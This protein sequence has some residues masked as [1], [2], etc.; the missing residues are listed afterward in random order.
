MGTYFHDDVELRYA[1]ADDNDEKQIEQIDA[2]ISEGINLL[3][4]SPNQVATISP[5]IDRAFDR[6]IPVIVFDRK[7]SS[8]KFTAYIGADNENMG[9]EMG[10]YIAAQLKGKGRVLEIMGLK[11]SSPAIERHQGFVMA[12]QKYPGI[13][14]VAS[15]Q[16][17]WTEKSGQQAIEGLRKTDPQKVSNIDYVFGQNDRMAVGAY[18][19]LDGAHNPQ[20][21]FCGIDALPTKGGGMECVRDGILTA[22]YIYPTH[23]DD[24]LQLAVNILKKKDY[25]KDNPLKGALVTKDNAHVLLMQ[26]EEMERQKEDLDQLH[27]K[28]DDTLAVLNNQNVSLITLIII[29]F[30]LIALCTYAYWAYLTK[31]RF[32]QQ[33]QESYERQRQ[34]TA[35]IEEMTKAQLMFFTN[36][37]HEF[38]TPLTLI[39]DPVDHLLADNTLTDSNRRL[40]TM[41]RRNVQ[42]LMQLINEVLDFR[43]V[44]SGKMELQ[45][46]TFDLREAIARWTADFETTA[47]KKGVILTSS[48]PEEAVPVEADFTKVARIYFN[49]MSNALKF[50][51]EGGTV[52]TRLRH[53]GHDCTLTVEDTGIGMDE[54][55][56][57]HIFD[58]F[59]QSKGTSGGTGI[60][61]SL[62]KAF[63]ELHHGTATVESRKGEGSAFTVVLPCR[64]A[65]VA[66][67][68]GGDHAASDAK[69]PQQ[70]SPEG[71]AAITNGEASPQEGSE[72]TGESDG[73]DRPTIL[74]IDDNADVRD[75]LNTILSPLYNVTMAANGEAGLQEA[76]REVPDLVVCDVMMPVMNGLEFCNRMKSETATSHIPVILLTARTLE[77]QQTEGYEHG[78]D[79][80][81]TKPFSSRL[82]L[83]RIDNL[84]RSRIQLKALFTTDSREQSDK[85]PQP[86]SADKQQQQSS[87]EQQLNAT[88]KAFIDRLRTIIET[89]M[90]DTGFGVEVIG[91]EIG[92]SRVQ[93][94]RKV[95]ALTGST[96]VDLIRK[97]RL[98]R[99]RHLLQTTGKSISEVAYTVGFSAPSYFTKCF[100]EEYGMLPNE[101]VKA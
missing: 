41:V 1:S 26:N 22:S 65:V 73:Q 37:S 81:I 89:H 85:A 29:V 95:K 75:Y 63:A 48:L 49:L 54:N 38:R 9:H 28:V 40:L 77:S 50:T 3:I 42:V 100:K 39:A 45:L 94:Y 7:T 18:H 32:S 96:P 61:L 52:E 101:V 33:L 71:G 51:P 12:L 44:Q 19:A 99:A 17:D 66:G 92:L 67:P 6:G 57:Q 74:V 5:A 93:L 87:E 16:G 79:S 27:E 34:L 36:V 69:A 47:Q 21:R 14:L 78:A 10:E 24:V 23:G 59:F 8:K 60:G 43:K 82:L 25:K 70:L 20:T 80:Y 68:A 56:R 4:V 97:A 72:V 31:A 88:D 11:G 46:S 53:D 98:A 76:S 2:F 90:A 35:E 84:L 15:L 13:E 62:V 91:T 86:A 55:D 30:L 58:R 64:Q 83:A